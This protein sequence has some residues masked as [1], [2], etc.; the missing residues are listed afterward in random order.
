[1]THHVD[2][3]PPTSTHVMLMGAGRVLR[4]GPIGE[5]LDA[6]GLS[7]TFG[8]DLELERRP[9]GRFSAWARR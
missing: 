2:D 9:N 6:A 3:I 4:A 8:L 1:V 7:E 5:V